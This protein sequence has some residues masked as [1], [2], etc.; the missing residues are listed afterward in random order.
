MAVQR[1]HEPR[2]GRKGGRLFHL[3]IILAAVVIVAA[4]AAG[5]LVFF[6][7]HTFEVVGN[8]RY[9]AEELLEAANIAED[10]NLVRIPTREIARRMEETMPYLKKV[11]VRLIPPERVV[12]E[13]TETVPS[14]AIQAGGSVWYIDS[15][16]KL[17]EKVSS[18]KG[19]PAITGIS[20]VEPEVGTYFQVSEEESL[21]A[22]GLR[23]LLQALEQRSLLTKVDQISVSGA[24]SISMHYD[25]RL[26]V[27]MGLNDDFAYD[28]KM[29]LAAEEG[30]IAENW[31]QGE[32]GTL[33]MTKREGEAVLSLDKV[34][35]S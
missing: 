23:G 33:D 5:S 21:K 35:E 18:N 20:I 14:G 2:S 31:S 27:K 29:L 7:A 26:T 34:G 8:S 4:A 6:K 9:S 28:I 32:T 17:L 13:V 10:T 15:G 22:K 12:L 24:S 16:G 25:N 30:Y 3:Y 19:Y 11:H 1:K